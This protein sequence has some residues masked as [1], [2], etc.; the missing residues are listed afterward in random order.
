MPGLAVA[1]VR[2]DAP[3]LETALTLQYKT[4]ASAPSA[5]AHGATTLFGL[6]KTVLCVFAVA[7][8]TFDASDVKLCVFSKQRLTFCH[9]CLTRT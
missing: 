1:G 5:G 6:S 4:F 8:V 9:K 3:S 2:E 7:F